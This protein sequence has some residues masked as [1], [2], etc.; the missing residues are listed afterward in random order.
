MN[1]GK[2]NRTEYSRR[3]A[4]G[5]AGESRSTGRSTG[6][7]GSR[8]MAHLIDDLSGGAHSPATRIRLDP[9]LDRA[10]SSPLPAGVRPQHPPLRRQRV[11]G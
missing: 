6:A 2:A 3:C 9:N 4:L 1:H 7:E 8:E 11:S 5:I 10:G